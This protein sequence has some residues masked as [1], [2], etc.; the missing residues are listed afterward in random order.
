LNSFILVLVEEDEEEQRTC[1][2]TLCCAVAL[3]AGVFIF[4]H[5]HVCERLF[6]FQIVTVPDAG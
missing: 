4:N 6:R 5:R 2:N 3:L 1:C